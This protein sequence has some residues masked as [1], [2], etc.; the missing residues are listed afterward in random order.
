MQPSLAFIPTGLP[1]ERR[2]GSKGRV[3][4]AGRTIVIIAVCIIA[5]AVLFTFDSRLVTIVRRA[6]PPDSWQQRIVTLAKW[7]LGTPT[8]IALV[9]LLLIHPLREQLMRA[10]IAVL[11]LAA[12]SLHLLKSLVGRARP[13]QGFGPFHFV[14]FSDPNIGFDAF[15]SGHTMQAFLIALLL[16]AYLPRLWRIPIVLATMVAIS[17]IHRQRAHGLRARRSPC[18]SEA[19]SSP[20]IRAPEATSKSSGR[21]Y[22]G[23]QTGQ[24]I[25]T[26]LRARR[27]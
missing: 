23:A 14:P 25:H 2:A 3:F 9:A 7:P 26:L 4:R 1:G 24:T 13:S 21:R 20:A 27:S 8:T 16:Q 10:F 5:F 15:P 18:V 19:L 17:R 6:L 11:L 12:C 22:S